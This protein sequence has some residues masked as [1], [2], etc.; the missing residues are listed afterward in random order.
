VLVGLAIL[1]VVL[2]GAVTTTS[3]S[4]TVAS[5]E[6]I[7]QQ[8]PAPTV[9]DTAFPK[10]NGNGTHNLLTNTTSNGAV[11]SDSSIHKNQPLATNSTPPSR[12][13]D[14]DDDDNNN[15]NNNNNNNA[16]LYSAARGD[17]SGAVIQDML[18]AHA[19]AF[20]NHQTYGGACSKY[21]PNQYTFKRQ[22]P[23]HEQ[24]LH[25]IGL[26]KVLP[27]A[28]SSDAEVKLMNRKDYIRNDTNIFTSDYLEYLQGLVQ[29]PTATPKQPHQIAVHIRRGDITPCRPRTRGY[30]RYLPNQHY[31][32]LIDRYNKNNSSHIVVYSESENAFESFEVL[33]ERGYQVILDGDIG[34][35]WKGLIASDVIILSR[36]SFSLVPA[37]ISKGT[38]VYTPFWHEPLPHWTV[39]DEILLN[40]THVEFRRL[41]DTCPKEIKKKKKNK[42]NAAPNN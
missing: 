3:S 15:N 31:L 17:R 29:Y 18:M 27:F 40:E 37:I 1:G 22:Q 38:V 10:S 9:Q 6:E 26:A 20:H 33:R 41:K 12:K 35:V 8:A 39:V 7:F 13:Y 25:A 2:A 34:H 30:P 21:L 4:L 14:D 16:M 36:S 19:Y 23:L 5:N 11:T 28:C 32:N 24:L 42:S